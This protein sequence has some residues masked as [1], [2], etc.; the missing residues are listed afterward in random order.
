MERQVMNDAGPVLVSEHAIERAG[1]KLLL[2]DDVAM[3]RDVLGAFLRAA[4]YVVI[5]TDGGRQA[6]RLASEHLFDLILMDVRMPDTDGLEATRHIRALPA[7]YG[8]VPVLALTSYGYTEQVAQCRLAGM[9][10]HVSKPVDDRTLVAAVDD[11]I[12]GPV[13]TV[14]PLRSEAVCT[15]ESPLRLDRSLLARA[16]ALLPSAEIIPNLQSLRIRLEQ[17]VRLLD[18]GADPS[19]LADAAHVLGSASGLFGFV[20]LSAAARSFERAATASAPNPAAVAEQLRTETCA[21]LAALDELLRESWSAV[22]PAADRGADGVIVVENDPLIRGII[23]GVLRDTR[24]QVF[25]AGDG[26]EA[27]ML[28][29]QFTPTLVLLDVA[30]PR[31]NGL[32]ACEAIRALA[33]LC[34][35]PDHHADRLR[36]QRHTRCGGAPGRDGF[37][38]ETFRAGRVAGPARR[39]HRST[40]LGV[41][42]EHCRCPG[43]GRAARDFTQWRRQPAGRVDQAGC[44]TVGCAAL[45]DERASAWPG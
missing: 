3:N 1:R 20:A 31:L 30:M 5:A 14:T 21:A 43:T 8:S 28:A 37:F 24:Q 16:L 6:I 44:R 45:A 19:M 41:A 40:R 29:R 17:M 34:G 36:R 10:G 7:P 2:V 23:R 39:S 15:E 27:V 25:L 33:G 26:I 18:Q 38:D 35:C 4:G 32:L 42:D 12:A 13:S 22:V 11:L 9:N